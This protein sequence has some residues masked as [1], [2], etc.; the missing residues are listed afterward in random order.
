MSVEYKI[1]SHKCQLSVTHTLIHDWLEKPLPSM[2]RVMGKVSVGLPVILQH[3]ERYA[4]SVRNI[5]TII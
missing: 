5:S 3:E 4:S 1:G 2:L